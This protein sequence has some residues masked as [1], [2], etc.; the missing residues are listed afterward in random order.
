MKNRKLRDF[1]YTLSANILN[2]FLGI[3]TGF[4][5]PK[6][7]G[8]N[9]YGYL[10]I[11][12][13]YVS[14]VGFLHFGF[15]D[16]IYIKYGSYEYDD[17]PKEKFRSYFR[18]LLLMQFAIFVILIPI[19]Y[20]FNSDSDRRSIMYFIAVNMVILNIT[21]FFSLINQFTRRFKLYSVNLVLTKILY[22]IGSI[23]F[24]AAGL[25]NHICFVI[26]QT[27]A[28]FIVLYSYIRHNKDLVW[29]KSEKIKNNI[30][31]IRNNFHIGF[32]VMIGNFMSII[33]IGL[34]RVF[35]DKFFTLKDFAMYSF[36]YS[37]ISVFYILL[38][39]LTTVVYPYLARTDQSKMKKT[40]ET[41][42]MFLI[43]IIGASLSGFF[44]LK[45]IVLK[46]L[47][48]YIDALPITLVLI[49]TVL[50]SGQN[51]ILIS[52]YYKVMKLQK[53][54]TF[55]NLVAF[56]LGLVTNIIAYLVFK[57]PL[58]IAIASLISFI[59]WL[60]YSDSFF[61]KKLNLNIKKAQLMEVITIALFLMIACNFSWYIGFVL[62]LVCFGIVMFLFGRTPGVLPFSGTT[63]GVNKSIVQDKL[64]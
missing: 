15:T 64:Q 23:I 54:Y 24:F 9:E 46:F 2:M 27:I 26:L 43:I 13:F 61:K 45:F 60:F 47:P 42:K 48:K 35:I 31:D 32:F 4:L 16:G 38:S 50:L 25:N 33:I 40:Y 37:M 18:F 53:E 17:L 49:P 19:T 34:D 51:S 44:I 8:V 39:S 21:A 14:Y 12:T 28:N 55:N 10:K 56:M 3:I 6:F 1:T 7:L 5:I 59:I 57:T 36:A 58:S 20:I 52:N 62:Y 11:F 30:K 29:G 41:I 22:V 63:P